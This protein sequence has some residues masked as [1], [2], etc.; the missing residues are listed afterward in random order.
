MKTTLFRFGLASLAGILTL[1]LNVSSA[2]AQQP[3]PGSRRPGTVPSLANYV[4]PTYLPNGM[5]LNQYA[6][7]V[8]LLAN[9][10]SQIPPWML[11]YN[12]YPPTIINITPYPTVPTYYPPP[13]YLMSPGY[14][15]GTPFTPL[16]LYTNPYFS[17]FRG[18][19]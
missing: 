13:P 10:Y 1:A 2:N 7:N 9:A 6:Y 12:P 11:G 16:G 5:T 3:R 4:P 17:F 15:L 14:P 8:S 18:F 19:P